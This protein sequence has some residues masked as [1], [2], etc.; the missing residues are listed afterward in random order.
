V[1]GAEGVRGAEEERLG[2]GE[3]SAPDF[4]FSLLSSSHRE[5]GLEEASR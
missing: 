1:Q 3:N 5:R 2:K 4:A